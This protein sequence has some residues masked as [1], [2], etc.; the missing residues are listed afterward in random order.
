MNRA[1]IKILLANLQK[2]EDAKL[3]SKPKRCVWQIGC[4]RKTFAVFFCYRI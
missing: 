3:E 1:K 4:K 2:C